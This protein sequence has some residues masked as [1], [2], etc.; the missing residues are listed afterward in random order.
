MEYIVVDIDGTV[1]LHG[2]ERGH[3][4]YGKVGGDKPN[5]PIIKLVQALRWACGYGVIFVSGRED[6]CRDITVEWLYNNFM[7]DDW[8]A[9]ELYMRKTGD[10]RKDSIIKREIYDAYLSDK[11][12]AYVLEDRNQVV[13]MWRELGLTCLQVA[14]GNF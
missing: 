6:S 10:W 5:I 14:D 13:Q 8:L 3:F 2:D 1:A 4:E 12:I 11:E 7:Q 9:Y